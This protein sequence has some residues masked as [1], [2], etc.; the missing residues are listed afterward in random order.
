MAIVKRL[1]LLETERLRIR[2]LV[3]DDLSV[4]HQLLDVELEW[5]GTIEERREWLAFVMRQAKLPN[6]PRDTAPSSDALTTS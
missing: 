1:T 2:P 5:S 4:A 3:A 6:P